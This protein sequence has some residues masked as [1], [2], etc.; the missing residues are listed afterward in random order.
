MGDSPKGNRLLKPVGAE[1][2]NTDSL[3][4]TVCDT[5]SAAYHL[6]FSAGLSERRFS[7][8]A[9][10][11]GGVVSL[12]LRKE[13][14]WQNHIPFSRSFSCNRHLGNKKPAHQCVPT[15]TK[16]QTYPLRF[17]FHNDVTGFETQS[18]NYLLRLSV[19]DSSKQFQKRRYFLFVYR[20]RVR[21]KAVL[22]NSVKIC[23]WLWF[24]R[25]SILLYWRKQMF[26]KLSEKFLNIFSEGGYTN[27]FS[28][29]KASDI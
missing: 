23:N 25:E 13:R 5:L 1:T 19:A 3:L 22:P 15:N 9:L 8:P 7:V 14:S 4:A 28:H 24:S 10:I 27:L 6:L 16:G 26:V 17:W 20:R 11:S 2:V 21:R 18:R 29:K 12:T